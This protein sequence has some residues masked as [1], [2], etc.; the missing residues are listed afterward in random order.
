MRGIIKVIQH[1][2]PDAMQSLTIDEILKIVVQVGTQKLEA[3][4]TPKPIVR[5]LLDRE[6]FPDPIWEP[7][8]GSGHIANEL[9]LRG[10]KVIASDLV[11][12]GFP[13]TK[14]GDFHDFAPSFEFSS[15]VTNPPYQSCWRWVERCFSFQ[16]EKIALLLPTGGLGD[17]VRVMDRFGMSLTRLLVL[18]RPPSFV[19]PSGTAHVNWGVSWFVL[20][21][22]VDMPGSVE[23]IG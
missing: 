21:K 23:A 18:R 8:V 7:A 17:V 20:T 16:P 22:G 19:G 4:W 5:A 2:T 10:H 12:Y 9:I 13:E 11:D 14:I 1:L 3:Y 6:R 15:I